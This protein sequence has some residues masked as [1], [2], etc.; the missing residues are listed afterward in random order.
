M[1]NRLQKSKKNVRAYSTRK[2]GSL[3]DPIGLDAWKYPE[4]IATA[5]TWENDDCNKRSHLD[6]SVTEV[7]YTLKQIVWRHY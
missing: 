6:A 1:W 3:V 7:E 4:P 2:R 5:K